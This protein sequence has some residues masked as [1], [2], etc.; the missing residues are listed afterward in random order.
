M[1]ATIITVA[2]ILG[3]VFLAVRTLKK[4]GGCAGC[5]GCSGCSA[6]ARQNECAKKHTGMQKK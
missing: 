6:C 5:S 4:S 3:I 2:I 1:A